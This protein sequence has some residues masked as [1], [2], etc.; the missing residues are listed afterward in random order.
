MRYLRQNGQPSI[1][2][3]KD[4]EFFEARSCEMK[5]LQSRGLGSKRHQPEPL[6][7]REEELLWESGQLGH[8][9]PQA[10][11]DTMLF[12]CGVY[13]ALRSGQEQISTTTN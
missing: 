11:V 13:F 5:R 3:F 9:S 1:D 7:E 10:L 4:T 8:H 2:F 6:T 12:M